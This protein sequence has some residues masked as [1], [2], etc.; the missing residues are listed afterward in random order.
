MSPYNLLTEKKLVNLALKSCGVPG[1]L[2]FSN[3]S[4]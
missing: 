4:I 3:V 1:I 2:E